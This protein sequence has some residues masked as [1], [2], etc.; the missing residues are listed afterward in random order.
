VQRAVLVLGQPGIENAEL[1]A[2]RYGDST[3]AAVQDY[4]KNHDPPII[5]TSYQQQADNIVGKM[6]IVALD[7]DLLELPSNDPRTNPD[8]STRIQQVLDQERLG[9]LLMIQ[10][11]LEALPQVQSAFRLAAVD[12]NAAAGLMF[13]QRFA[14]DGLERFFA[15]NQQNHEAFLP[16]IITNYQKYLQAFARLSLDQSPADYGFL[17]RHALFKSP[18]GKFFLDHGR[19][20]ADTPMGWS[21]R[22]LRKMF[23]SPRYR[24]FD[25]TM[26]P[27]FSGLFHEALQGIQIHEMGHF[28]FDFDDGSPTGQP[29]QRCIQLAVS[30]DVLARQITKRHLVR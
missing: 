23:F 7:E 18:D 22:S 10:T 30:Y 29:P 5:N 20:T 27:L 19:M 8:E 17:L 26:D 1:A 6:T 9:A 4:K 11:T 13:T 28:Y 3:A 12:P 21:D 14:I 15:V 25:P 24:Q 2:A 16:K